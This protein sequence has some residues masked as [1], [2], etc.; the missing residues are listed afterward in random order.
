V[1]VPTK[2]I[3]GIAAAVAER[4]TGTSEKGP[5]LVKK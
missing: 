2:A 1:R 3:L 4:L 5:K